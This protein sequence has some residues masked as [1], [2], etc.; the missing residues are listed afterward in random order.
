MQIQLDIVDLTARM[1]F[2]LSVTI[3]TIPKLFIDPL[4]TAFLN[5]H[6]VKQAWNIVLNKL[7]GINISDF[8]KLPSIV[9]F[10]APTMIGLKGFSG[11]NTI[12]IL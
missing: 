10:S 2:T 11:I 8:S 7:G 12:C 5:H 6:Q 3:P 4:V 1:V 9:V